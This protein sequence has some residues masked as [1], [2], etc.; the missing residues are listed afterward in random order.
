MADIS[1]QTSCQICGSLCQEANLPESQRSRYLSSVWLGPLTIAMLHS[2][3]RVW[4]P[5]CWGAGEAQPRSQHTGSLLPNMLRGKSPCL[6]AESVTG[7]PGDLDLEPSAK[8]RWSCGF[9]F[10]SFAAA[11]TCCEHLQKCQLNGAHSLHA[12]FVRAHEGSAKQ[13]QSSTC[14]FA[15]SCGRDLQ[16]AVDAGDHLSGVV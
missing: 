16:T 9:G 12:P 14:D 6:G 15:Y 8:L 13:S 7:R 10:W 1:S 2:S 5:T 3:S 4:C 11:K